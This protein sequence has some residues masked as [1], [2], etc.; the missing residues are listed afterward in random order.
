ML[1][2]LKNNLL[3]LGCSVCFGAKDSQLTFGL[4]MG[5]LTLLGIVYSVIALGI[6]F[7]ISFSRRA[8][9]LKAS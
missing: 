4:A 5:M 2:L 7:F 9:T 1:T 6:K 3:P 8:N